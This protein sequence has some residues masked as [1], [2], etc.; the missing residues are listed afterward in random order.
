MLIPSISM[1]WKN[2]HFHGG[3]I[4][5]IIFWL[6]VGQCVKISEIISDQAEMGLLDSHPSYR[7]RLKHKSAY[8]NVF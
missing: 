4:G 1:R 6:A 5:G 8:M 7:S 3:N 2:E